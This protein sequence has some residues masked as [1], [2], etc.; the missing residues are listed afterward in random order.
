MN[1][2]LITFLVVLL[3]SAVYAWRMP[4]TAVRPGRL[5][6]AH[7]SLEHHC[8]AC[9]QPGSGVPASRCTACHS[10]D[11]IG[12]ARVDGGVLE[13]PRHSIQGLHQ[14]YADGSCSECHREHTGR[15]MQQP[16]A[17]FTHERLPAELSDDCA[18]CHLEQT[19][20]DALHRQAGPSCG[21][22]HTVDSWLPATFDHG[23]L[24]RNGADCRSCH[25][26]DQPT[27]DLHKG[28]DPA[29]DCASCHHTN[30][31]TP[32]E[33][34]HDRYFRFDRNHPSRC[35][36]CHTPGKGYKQYGCMGC[37]AHSEANIAEEHREEGIR[38]WK[39][40]V[41]CHRSGDEDEAKGGEGG[42][43]RG[44]GEHEDDD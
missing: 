20:G 37:H 4:G 17:G 44:G 11:G 7:D 2:P 24:T 3:L 30:A 43:R 1:R 21:F 31:W 29:A 8:L 41:E 32:A 35:A 19:P 10:M 16:A 27:D 28:L 25:L 18:A 34:D 5:L 36:D 38:N 26:E 42:E 40:C 14:R 6:A 22:C 23:L 33:F 15:L 9:H 13:T 12:L 39:N